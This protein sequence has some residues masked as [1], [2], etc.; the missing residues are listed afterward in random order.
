MT[1][2]RL[3]LVFIAAAL[4]AA[5]AASAQ[6]RSNIS[7]ESREYRYNRCETDTDGYARLLSQQSQAPCIRGQTWGYDDRGVWVD[8]GCAGE[9]EVGG[10]RF[11]GMR[12][13]EP[14]SH[15]E[16]LTREGV[17]RGLVHRGGLRADIL[18]EGTI[19]VGDDI[20]LI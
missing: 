19:R 15:L 5:F 10:A 2:H 4:L 1:K 13:C 7:C 9:F 16:G 8:E 6:A 20:R 12:L 14:C 3:S 17:V 11:R 18:A